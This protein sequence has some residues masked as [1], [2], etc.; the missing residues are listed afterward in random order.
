MVHLFAASIARGIDVIM[1]GSSF[2]VWWRRELS[3]GSW[4]C[5][6]QL[7]HSVLAVV[8]RFGARAPVASMVAA[9]RCVHRL[10]AIDCATRDGGHYFLRDGSSDVAD[11]SYH[12]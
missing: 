8:E 4:R 12:C 3:S 2:A 11:R 6:G 10:A 7:V 5:F 9:V 1:G